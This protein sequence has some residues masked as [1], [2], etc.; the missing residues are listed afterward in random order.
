MINGDKYGFPL[1]LEDILPFAEAEHVL[2]RLERR[3]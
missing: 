2:R 3:A 1:L